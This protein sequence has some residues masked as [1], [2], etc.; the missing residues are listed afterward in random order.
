M[1]YRAS[2]GIKGGLV[3]NDF[4]TCLAFR[5]DGI[6]WQRPK[7]GVYNWLGSRDTNIIIPGAPDASV[8]IDP[9]GSDEERFKALACVRGYMPDDPPE[10][11]KATHL[12]ISPDGIHW[13]RSKKAVLP[14]RHDTQNVFFF[15]RRLGRYVAYVRWGTARIPGYGWSQSLCRAGRVRRPDWTYPGRVRFAVRQ[16]KQASLRR[17][18]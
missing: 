1:W 4:S 16:G 9:N 18:T 14:F 15:D 13:R 17:P 6:H 8:M 10:F 7:T 2:S 12:F 3:A 11:S 5:D